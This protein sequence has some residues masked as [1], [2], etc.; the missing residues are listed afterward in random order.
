MKRAIF[1]LLTLCLLVPA[2]VL[3]AESATSG[4]MKAVLEQGTPGDVSA[5]IEEEGRAVG[6]VYGIDAETGARGEALYVDAPLPADFADDQRVVIS[7]KP[8]DIDQT[9]LED[10]LR[11]RGSEPGS[12]TIIPGAAYNADVGEALPAPDAPLTREEAIA[13]ARAFIADCGL[14]D[15]WPLFALRPEEEARGL[16]AQEAPE[17][18]EA[19]VARQLREWHRPDTRYTSVRLMF[20]LRGLPVA[21]EWQDAAGVGKSSIVNLYIGDAGEIRDYS[22]WY[23]PR[24][25]S[26]EPVDGQLKSWQEAL[27]E[28]TPWFGAHNGAPRTDERGREAPPLRTTVTDILPGYASSDGKTFVPAW[29]F[30]TNT[31]A[32]GSDAPVPTESIWVYAIDARVGY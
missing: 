16:A 17:A 4:V 11:A 6:P 27:S 13:I 3:A 14:G 21:P 1:L 22:L 29:I 28:L 8:I 9:A 2:C 12:M 20:T 15:T 31:F 26:A 10:A 7:A 25:V 19:S 23:A 5:V 30:V 32:L 24:E 18:R